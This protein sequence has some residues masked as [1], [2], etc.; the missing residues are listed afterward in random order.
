MI[1]EFIGRKVVDNSIKPLPFKNRK[2]PQLIIGQDYYVSFGNNNAYPCTL[3]NVIN[4][5]SET[6]VKI[7]IHIRKKSTASNIK[8]FQ[9]NI[10]YSIEI[11]LT[12][13]DA[14]RNQV[15]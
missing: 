10:L 7:E 6:E 9:T 14:V 4:E 5:F 2:A 11:G 12:P 13:D 15:G 1:K 8:T 3:L